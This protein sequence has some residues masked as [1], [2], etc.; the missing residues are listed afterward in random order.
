MKNRSVPTDTLLAQL[1][2]R[3]V[4]KTIEWLSR[5][6]G[7]TEHYH[8]GPPG[9]IQ[10]AQMRLGNAWFMI[11]GERPGRRSPADA[12]FETQTL[13]VYLEDVDAHYAMAKAQGAEIL[14]ELRETIY[15]ERLYNVLDLDGHWW[16]F[17]QHVRDLRP[18][19]WGATVVHP[20]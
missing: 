16:E 13:T 9:D 6:F 3:D 14:E 11:H 8:Y 1:T 4:A 5:V 10:G 17:S 7:F 15:G 19:E 12:G 2:Y 18:E 20:L